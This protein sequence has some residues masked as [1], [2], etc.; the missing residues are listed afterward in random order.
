MQIHE[1]TYSTVT[2][3]ILKT[4]GQDIKGAVTEP[5]QKLNAIANTPGAWT[6]GTIAGGALDQLER[7]KIDAQVAQQTA[8]KAKQL[9][10]QWAQQVKSMPPAKPVIKPLQSKQPT[11]TVG[12]QLLTKGEDDGL[13]H[14]EDGR[15]V[16]DPT[17]AARIDKA[18][19]T[20]QRN[21]KG[22][23]KEATSATNN[24]QF[25]TWSDQQLASVIPGT[26]QPMTMSMVRKD[27]ETAK[28]LTADTKLSTAFENLSFEPAFAN[29]SIL[30]F[31]N[32]D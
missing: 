22:T 21:V 24:Q 16:T 23:V 30:R 15:A 31:S 8:Q 13:W 6:S 7:G 11:V 3:G 19:Y 5:F 9:A 1:I 2:E 26:R 27:P 25:V 4:I 17:Q 32:M 14:G 10:Q 18:Y 20:G 28:T 12:G 29:V